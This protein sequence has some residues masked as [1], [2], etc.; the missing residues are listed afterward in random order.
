MATPEE[1]MLERQ[2][3]VQGPQMPPTD[4]EGVAKA[5]LKMSEKAGVSP[6]EAPLFP[7]EDPDQRQRLAAALLDREFWTQDVTRS[8]VT[9]TKNVV[10]N[11][12]G[13]AGDLRS[14][15]PGPRGIASQPTSEEIAA[16]IGGDPSHPTW[17]PAAL[18]APGPGEI[19]GV[20]KASLVGLTGFV[21]RFADDLVEAKGSYFDFLKLE[22]ELGSGPMDMRT[23]TA[24]GWVRGHDGAPKF[25][26]SDKNMK[27]RDFD[28]VEGPNTVR[29]GDLV[30]H[31][32]LF[33]FYP[34]IANVKLT[35]YAEKSPNGDI[36]IRRKPGKDEPQ[37]E[38]VRKGPTQQD[39]I[40][41]YGANSLRA[42][43]GSL[44]HEASHFIQEVEGWSTGSKTYTKEFMEKLSGD[45]IFT[46]MLR[47]LDQDA[48]ADPRA[49]EEFVKGIGGPNVSDKT[50]EDTKQ[51]ARIFSRF[52]E[53]SFDLEKT[54][55]QRN[56]DDALSRTAHI[57]EFV[58]KK[59]DP[60]DIDKITTLLDDAGNPEL[61]AQ[62]ERVAYDLKL[63]EVEARLAT[64]LQSWDDAMWRAPNKEDPIETLLRMESGGL[65][66]PDAK[67]TDDIVIGR[68]GD[69]KEKLPDAEVRP[70]K[71]APDLSKNKLPPLEPYTVNPSF[72]ALEQVE[73]PK[74]LEELK[75]IQDK[76][77]N[78]PLLEALFGPNIQ[79]SIDE[80][81]GPRSLPTES[82]GEVTEQAV[83]P[84]INMD[85]IQRKI[86]MSDPDL[87]ENEVQIFTRREAKRIEENFEAMSKYDDGINDLYLESTLHGTKKG[88]Q[89]V[90]MLKNPTEAEFNR[91]VAKHTFVDDEL[92]EKLV[93]VLTDVEGNYYIWDANMA[94]HDDILKHTGMR[95]DVEADWTDVDGADPTKVFEWL[96]EDRNVW[97]K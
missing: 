55:A 93:R 56:V 32:D 78:D 27:I 96:R 40:N 6:L 38:L 59:N 34:D 14:M 47:K 39:E 2:Q 20:S 42:F 12:A 21:R 88:K 84:R 65:A 63:G 8:L 89:R 3:A 71:G 82:L 18:L 67:L 17:W 23:A 45:V 44:L 1:R 10:A 70:T 97:I 24:T 95:Y 29:F 73:P 86:R 7:K 81:E 9:G 79:K 52:D 50:V 46:R 66:P 26:V 11:T 48:L 61:L 57:F 72:K 94:L 60:S 4:R 19:A 5:A 74:R 51:L 41:V 31:E 76:L 33:K 83:R 92:N 64:A 53:S 62:Y 16:S 30:E 91:W 80:I 13:L 49:V 58:L 25:F 15:L 87:T 68:R 43:K 85:K 75:R 77:K 69:M 35:V 22:K 54:T 36:V 28:F 37:A 90:E